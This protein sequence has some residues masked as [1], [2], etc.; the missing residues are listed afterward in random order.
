MR[1]LA[2]GGGVGSLGGAGQG[3]GCS[4]RLVRVECGASSRRHV[5][6]GLQSGVCAQCSLLCGVAVERHAVTGTGGGGHSAASSR[7][8]TKP[9]HHHFLATAR[10]PPHTHTSYTALLPMSPPPA[11][12][13]SVGKSSLLTELTGTESEAAAYEFT[14]LT[15]IP[16]VIHYND[17]KIQLL[18]LPG[19]IEGAAEGKGRGRQVGAGRGWGV[20]GCGRL[21]CIA[22]LSQ[23]TATA[24]LIRRWCRHCEPPGAAA[25]G[26]A[27][28]WSPRFPLINPFPPGRTL[29]PPTRSLRCASPRTC[30]SWCWTPPSPSTT[31]RWARVGA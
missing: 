9:P 26:L 3:R 5:R 21:C 12:F 2:S 4:D 11:G 27:P 19:I 7:P 6:R 13:P 22:A 17:S 23:W 8:H 20:G 15:C 24:R 10:T 1:V 31:S 16:G 14:T 28:S 29:P 30:C 18:D 25:T